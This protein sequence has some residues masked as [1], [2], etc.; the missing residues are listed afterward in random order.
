MQL[1]N[2]PIR[3]TQHSSKVFRSNVQIDN[4]HLLDV[5]QGVYVQSLHYIGEYK[6][7]IVCNRQFY[8]NSNSSNQDDKRG[9]GDTKSIHVQI[10]LRNF[11][12]SFFSS[13]K[14]QY[15]MIYLD[16]LQIK[17]QTSTQ[18]CC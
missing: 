1:Y 8:L 16:R 12:C 5:H 9:R 7:I 14:L 13:V 10:K 17:K 11:E 6:Y 15:L 3:L 4:R 2:S 18:V